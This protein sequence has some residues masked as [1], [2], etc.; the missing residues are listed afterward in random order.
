M[1]YREA[2]VTLEEELREQH[3]IRV[4]EQIADEL[5]RWIADYYERMGTFPEFPTEEGGGSRAML[6]RQGN[7]IINITFNLNYVYIS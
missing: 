6:S 2:L 7:M 5:R 1:E 4:T 3:G